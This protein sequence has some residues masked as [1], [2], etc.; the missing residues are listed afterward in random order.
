ML[1]CNVAQACMDRNDIPLMVCGRCTFGI[2]GS[3]DVLFVR[4]DTLGSSNAKS[5]AVLH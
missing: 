3:S 5:N 4:W 2:G 1:L